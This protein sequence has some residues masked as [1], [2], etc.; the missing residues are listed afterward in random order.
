MTLAELKALMGIPESDTSQDAKLQLYLDM[1]LEAAR[2]YA[3][4]Y[5][6]SSTEPLPAGLRLGIVRFVE[7]S[8]SRKTNTGV[9]SE[10][11]GGMSRTYAANSNNDVDYFGEVWSMWKPFKKRGV[12]FRSAK[13]RGA[14]NIDYLIPDDITITGTRKL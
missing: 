14:N 4:A 7:L 5:D 11:I 10:S 9:I 6:W 1:A 12:V 3:N 2:D 8:Q 13:R